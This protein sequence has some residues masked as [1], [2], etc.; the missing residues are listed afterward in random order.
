M[1]GKHQSAASSQNQV[2]SNDQQNIQ[3]TTTNTSTMATSNISSNF[4]GPDQSVNAAMN[5][6]GNI[7]AGS[8]NL[9]DQDIHQGDISDVLSAKQGGTTKMGVKGGANVSPHIKGGKQSSKGA[10]MSSKQGQG[11]SGGGSSMGQ[12]IEIIVVLVIVVAIGGGIYYYMEN[13]DDHG[14]EGMGEEWGRNGRNAIHV[15]TPTIN[16]FVHC[17][18]QQLNPL[19]RM[20]LV[21]FFGTGT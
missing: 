3:N 15:K 1:G 14:D 10:K 6:G 18:T 21:R 11:Q 8:H 20:E 7:G 19:R 9:V 17:K 16:S 4:Q 12:M 13:K 5:F 2:Q